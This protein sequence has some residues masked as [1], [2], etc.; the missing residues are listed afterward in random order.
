VLPGIL[1]QEATLNGYRASLSSTAA[2]FYLLNLGRITMPNATGTHYRVEVR[3]FQ[4]AALYLDSLYKTGW[5]VIHM[6]AHPDGHQV[7]CLLEKGEKKT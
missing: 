4:E 7:I 1:D 5:R 6:A 2:V 3:S